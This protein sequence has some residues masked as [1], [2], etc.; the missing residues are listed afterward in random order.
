[1]TRVRSIL[2]CS[3]WL[4]LPPSLNAQS[5]RLA[6]ADRLLSEGRFEQA[7]GVLESWYSSEGE[8]AG[9][10]DRQ[11]AIWL[12]AL[13]TTDPEFSELDYRRL[14]IEYPGGP[15]SDGALLRLAQGARAWGDF[16]AA[17]RYL[18]ILVRDYPQ[19]PLRP[20]ARTILA[21]LDQ[22][23]A[24][25]GIARAPE[26]P[27]PPAPPATAAPSPPSAPSPPAAPS[28]AQGAFTLQ[29]GA[30]STADR[31][32]VMAAEARAAGFE[33]R[34]VRVEGNDL[35]RVRHGA[36]AT[37]EEADAHARAFRE[38]GFEVG[39]STD[40]ERETGG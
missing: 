14:V 20:E 4:L 2:L 15:Y 21:R 33:V 11:H 36:F 27:S 35:I 1:M 9:R 30:F 10:V 3:L 12:R 37:R 31:A 17:R 13:L 7:R 29:L 32:G 6:E 34:I 5:P 22:P 39:I 23:P 24:L 28:P 26:T 40:R 18:E 16:E 38:R 19:S 25:M 8:A